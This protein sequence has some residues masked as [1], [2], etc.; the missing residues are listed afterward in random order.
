MWRYMACHVQCI[1]WKLVFMV[2]I[3]KETNMVKAIVRSI[4]GI[5]IV[6]LVSLPLVWLT[7]WG[8]FS[9]SVLDATQG[10]K[11]K[12]DIFVLLFFIGVILEIPYRIYVVLRTRKAI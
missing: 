11:D 6:I 10:V 2:D 1:F 4:L 7:L 12:V 9:Y 8:V 3:D 5:F